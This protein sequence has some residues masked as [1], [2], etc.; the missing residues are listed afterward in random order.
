METT[1]TLTEAESVPSSTT[2]ETREQGLSPDLGALFK[3]ELSSV[4]VVDSPKSRIAPETQEAPPA[5]V[6]PVETAPV[7][8]ETFPA[9]ELDETEKFL[10]GVTPKTANRFNELLNKK[11]DEKAKTLAETIVAERLKTAKILNPET[12]AK[13]TGLEKTNT[14]LLAELRKVGVERSPEYLAKFVEGPKVL[15]NEIGGILD[16]YGVNKGEFFAALA[17]PMKPENRLKLNELIDSVGKLDSAELAEK[18]RQL[19]SLEKQ[20]TIVT[21]DPELAIEALKKDHE[22]RTKAFVDNLQASRKAA[23]P[24]VLANAEKEGQEW[25]ATQDGAKFKTELMPMIE[26]INSADL[27]AADPA[28]RAQIITAAAMTKPLYQSF[29]SRGKEITELKA[30]LAKYE[31]GTPSI[32]GRSADTAPV[33]EEPTSVFSTAFGYEPTRKY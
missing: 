1:E 19:T 4:K 27:E 29:V 26:Q 24:T 9:V 10:K 2:T 15:K 13:L 17:D 5:E 23:L 25:F 21:A 6:P 8:T 11:S 31:K 30:K 28:V 7:A 33:A 20:K 12:E 18:T 3:A 14:E 16:V 22:A 32:G